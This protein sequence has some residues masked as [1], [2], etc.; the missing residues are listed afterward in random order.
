MNKY[1]ILIGGIDIAD[2]SENVKTICEYNLIIF[3]F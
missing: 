2:S 1:P 3:Y